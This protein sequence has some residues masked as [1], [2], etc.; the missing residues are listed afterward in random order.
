ML[1]HMWT[2]D[3]SSKLEKSLEKGLLKERILND[4]VTSVM[5]RPEEKL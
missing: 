3:S 1:L 4:E 2:W 5:E